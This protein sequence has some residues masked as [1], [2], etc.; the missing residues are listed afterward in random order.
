MSGDPT[1]TP[2]QELAA[3]AVATREAGLPPALVHDV[4]RRIL[5]VMGNSLGASGYEPARIALQV[6]RAW[7]SGGKAT[8]FG[9]GEKLPA[10]AAALVNGTLA[11]TLDFDDTHLPSVLHPSASVI[12]AALAVAEAEGATG[13]QAIVAAAIGIEINVRLGSAG[14]DAA[15]NQNLFFE[16]GL[17]ATS[18]CGALAAAATAATLMGLDAE[19]IG[20]AIAISA[21]MGAGLLE[22][23]RTGGTVKR[24]HCGWAAHSGIAAAELARA[25]LTGPLTVMEGRFG[26]LQATCGERAD[27]GWL[28]R[29]LGTDWELP[30]IGFKPYPCNHFTHPGIDAALQLRAAGLDPHEIESIVLGAPTSVLRTIGEPPEEKARPQSGYHAQFSGP[31]TVAS[32]LVG[33]GGLGLYLDDFSDELARDPLRL[34]L[35]AKV[36]CIP[37]AECDTIFPHHFPA[38]LTVTTTSGEVREAFVRS[39]RGGLES[40]LSDDEL[41]LKFALNAAR[42]IPAEQAAAL[43]QAVAQLDSAPD[44]QEFISQSAVR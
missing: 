9:S 29:G 32:A 5:D 1:P 33:G 7:G 27:V 15:T 39:S 41:G 24:I 40:P 36:T 18:I 8:A 30:K 22:A 31:F 11:H 6:A 34:A 19:Q 4:K 43:R 28:T 3:F 37:D 13:L 10:A 12:P 44:L 26:F 25:G 42:A 17:H 2:L 21:S 35:A 38:R 16:H 20:H 23:N 14:F